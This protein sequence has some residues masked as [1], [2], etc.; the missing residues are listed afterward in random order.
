MTR[1]LAVLIALTA[2]ACAALAAAGADVAP[3][4]PP[5]A[6][7]DRLMRDFI[8]EHD[9]PGGALAVAKDGRLVYAR[10]FGFADLERHEQARPEAQ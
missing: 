5:L 2:A 4:D 8:K 7:F 6:G 3:A 10:G 9:V 1:T